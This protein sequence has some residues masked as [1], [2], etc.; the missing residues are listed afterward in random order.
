MC[1]G[2]NNNYMKYFFTICLILS[3]TVFGSSQQR[4]AASKPGTTAT[5]QPAKPRGPLPYVMKKDYDSSMIKLNNKMAA[6]Q[7]SINSVKSGI[8]G[9]D[10]VINTLQSQMKQVEEVLNSTNFKISLTSDSLSQTR[11]SM[12]EAQKMN[13]QKFVELQENLNTV[14]STTQYLW[15]ALAVLL[16]LPVAIWF[17]LNKKIQ[18]LES[19][20]KKAQNENKALLEEASQNQQKAHQQLDQQIRLEAKSN[21]HYAERLHASNKEEIASLRNE[22]EKIASTLQIITSELNDLHE[23]INT[24]G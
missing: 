11:F 2:A 5:P 13:E 19:N 21:Q 16:I 9:K 23:K 3:I 20:L 24:K 7:G 15:M 1:I 17:M 12:E 4:P 8:N 22:S 6:I 18:A 10:A 14:K